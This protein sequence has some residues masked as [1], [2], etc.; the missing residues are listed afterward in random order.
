MITIVIRGRIKDFGTW[1]VGYDEADRF[2]VRH[3][4]TYASLHRDAKDPNT[5]IMVHQFPDTLAAEAFLDDVMPATEEATDDGFD[6]LDVWVG[7]DVEAKR[8]G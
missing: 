4:I 6:L 2:R 1:K 5:V 7:E 8:Y 3:G